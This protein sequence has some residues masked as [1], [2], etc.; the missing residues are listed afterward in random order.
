MMRGL[1]DLYG[2]FRLNRPDERV[3]LGRDGAARFPAALAHA[4][5][6][7]AI[8]KSGGPIDEAVNA[9]R[10]SVPR[11][12]A[13]QSVLAGSLLSWARDWRGSDRIASLVGQTADR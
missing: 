9:A 6:I 13:A 12:A 11:T 8:A 4:Y 5:A 10:T 3:R 1:V 2:P 7:C